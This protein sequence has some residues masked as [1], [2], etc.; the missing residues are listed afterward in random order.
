MTHPKLRY[1]GTK[2]ICAVAMTR[3]A[4][5]ELRGW[6]LPGDENGEDEG[7][8]VEYLDGGKANVPGYAGYVSWSPKE[9]FE[10]AYR[11]VAHS[12]LATDSADAVEDMIKAAGATAPRVTPEKLRSVIA[13]VMWIRPLGTLMICIVTLKNGF[14]VTGESACVDPANCR[15]EI[16]RRVSYENAIRKIWPLEGYR[17]AEQRMGPPPMIVPEGTFSEVELLEMSKHGRS[18]LVQREPAPMFTEDPAAANE[19]Q[20][21]E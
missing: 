21:P 12:A 13:Q 16:G 17:L 8:L 10:N 15:E 3:L 19:A 2:M 7:F 9:V 18:V 1:I 14:N 4:Y 20:K 5:N 6:T 11:P